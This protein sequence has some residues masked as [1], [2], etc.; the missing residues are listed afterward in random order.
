ME[1]TTSFRGVNGRVPSRRPMLNMAGGLLRALLRSASLHRA[2]A[3]RAAQLK[4]TACDLP[5][6]GLPAAFDGYRLL[7][8]SDL[9]FDASPHATQALYRTIEGLEVDIVVAT[10]DFVEHHAH[11]T[12]VAAAA[13][14][15]LKALLA[16]RHGVVATLGNHDS[17]RT[18]EALE[19]QG[20]RVLIN[21]TMTIL[22]G[23]QRIA[24]TGIDDPSHF[25]DEAAVE[26]L[27]SDG[28]GGTKIAL[29]H[30]PELASVAAAGG[31][32]LY[33][34]GHTHGGQIRLP[35]LGDAAIDLHKHREY[36]RGWWRHDGMVGYTS[37]GV[38]TTLAALRFNCPAEVLMITLRA[39]A[40][41]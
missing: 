11:G 28:N 16:P 29:A 31:Y 27:A 7:H 9:H 17:W 15:K 33:L 26:A 18:A 13:M 1:R 30:S 39:A 6:P 19:D 41:R 35:L 14:C 5:L 37:R 3:E 10:G 4:L 21:E 38:G 12:P 2:A 24:V 36:S 40:P 32:H 8:L 34:A 22:H 23:G 20:I 25:F